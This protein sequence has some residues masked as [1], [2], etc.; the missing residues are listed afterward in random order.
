MNNAQKILT[1]SGGIQKEAYLLKV[2]CIT[3]LSNT[4]WDETVEDGWNVLVGANTE[5]IVN[6]ARDFE[7]CGK[8]REDF[9]KGEACKNIKNAIESGAK[10]MFN[11]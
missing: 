3:L 5:K 1:D 7:P 10:T 11:H 6:M 9:G 8:Q 2:P 4:G